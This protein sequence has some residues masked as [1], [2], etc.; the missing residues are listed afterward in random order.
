[1]CAY[2]YIHVHIYIHIYIHIW[3]KTYIHVHVYV[4]KCIYTSLYVQIYI[5]IYIDICICIYIYTLVYI[6]TY[7][8]LC[9]HMN[10]YICIYV[11]VYILFVR[12]WLQSCDA[13]VWCS[14]EIALPLSEMIALLQQNIQLLSKT[15]VTLYVCI[16]T[17]IQ[18][19]N[20]CNMHRVWL[21]SCDALGWCLRECL[22]SLPP[23]PVSTGV[24][25]VSKSVMNSTA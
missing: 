23:A 14:S 5:H 22:A 2:I 6:Y 10:A 7:V 1:V 11:C 13:L 3:K 24:C 12:I 18:I 16:F 17:F 25:S 8:N 19:C 21:Q 20:A 4:Y 15:E 9:I